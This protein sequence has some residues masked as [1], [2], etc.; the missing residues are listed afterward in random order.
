[1]TLRWNRPSR[2]LPAGGGYLNLHYEKRFVKAVKYAIRF[3]FEKLV[4][5][6]S[7]NA[8]PGLVVEGAPISI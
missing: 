8:N 1:M 2:W 7:Q 6:T 3:E 5:R 4:G